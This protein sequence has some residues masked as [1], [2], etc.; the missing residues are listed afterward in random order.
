MKKSRKSSK[1]SID[2]KLAARDKYLRKTYGITLLDYNMKLLEQNWGCAVCK[3]HYSEFKSSLAVDH[4]HKTGKVRG[5]LCYY[6]NHRLIG[7]HTIESARKIYY[8]L[9][10]YDVEAG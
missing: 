7:R 9:L 2:A 4:S 5:L 3:K 1:T 6:C 10:K 8:Y